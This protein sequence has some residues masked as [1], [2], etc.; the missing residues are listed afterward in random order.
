METLEE[1]ERCSEYFSFLLTIYY[2]L[3]FP[4]KS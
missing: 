4:I 1:Y 3:S 2:F